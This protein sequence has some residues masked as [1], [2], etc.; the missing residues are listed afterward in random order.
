M[1]FYSQ[2]IPVYQLLRFKQLIFTCNHLMMALMTNRTIHFFIVHN[3][4][5][6]YIWHKIQFR[7]MILNLIV[8]NYF[9]FLYSIIVTRYRTIRAIQLWNS[10]NNSRPLKH[11]IRI[12]F[13]WINQH[14]HYRHHHH[15][16]HQFSLNINSWKNCLY[17]IIIFENCFNSIHWII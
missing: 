17:F 14:N 11:L 13:H 9:K 16:V 7:C 12:D 15:N 2:H 6:I 10:L 5:K 3:A 4:Y 1:M 8:K